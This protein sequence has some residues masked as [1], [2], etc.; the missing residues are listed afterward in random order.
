MTTAIAKSQETLYWLTGDARL[1]AGFGT[2][3]HDGVL[4]PTMAQPGVN[5]PADP[6]AGGRLC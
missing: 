5:Q 1:S 2:S 3:R 6:F 4:C